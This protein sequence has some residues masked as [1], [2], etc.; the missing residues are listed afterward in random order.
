MGIINAGIQSIAQERARTTC[1]IERI[2]SEVTESVVDEMINSASDEVMNESVDDISIEELDALLKELPV[3]ADMEK[4]EI[5]RVLA[6]EDE[7]ID[8]DDIVGV[9]TNAE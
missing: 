2:H 7:D 3:D 6:I 8:I 9:V 5:A 1:R 4:E